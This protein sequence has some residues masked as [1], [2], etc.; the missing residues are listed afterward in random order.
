[1]DRIISAHA[2]YYSG[3]FVSNDCSLLIWRE[4]LDLSNRV[5]VLFINSRTTPKI[6]NAPNTSFK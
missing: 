2:H 3:I 5:V 1:M 6:L 4:M